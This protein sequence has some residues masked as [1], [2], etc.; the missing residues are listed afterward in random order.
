MWKNLNVMILILLLRLLRIKRHSRT[1]GAAGDDKDEDDIEG[2]DRSAA[3]AALIS[4]KDEWLSTL[5]DRYTVFITATKKKVYV[6]RSKNAY[7]DA[8]EFVKESVA[9]FQVEDADGET[10]HPIVSKLSLLNSELQLSLYIE[11]GKQKKAEEK[12]KQAKGGDGKGKGKNVEKRKQRSTET[13]DGVDDEESQG[14]SR[15]QATKRARHARVIDSEDD[16]EE[17]V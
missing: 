13:M 12:G 10:E 2:H 1:S 6:T 17:I 5:A 16:S 4:L 3:E 14:P 15:E 11:L 8:N 9:F 7:A